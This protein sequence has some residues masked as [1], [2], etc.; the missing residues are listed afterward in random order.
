MQ[1]NL[2]RSPPPFFVSLI[3]CATTALGFEASA[4][5]PC[6][7]EIIE[8]FYV[9]VVH[10]FFMETFDTHASPSVYFIA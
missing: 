4:S 3:Q 7:Q 8:D 9:L 1:V 6:E 5:C 2:D 10:N